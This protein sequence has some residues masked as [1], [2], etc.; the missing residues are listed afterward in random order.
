MCIWSFFWRAPHG[1]RCVFWRCF[2]RA[3]V[4]FLFTIPSFF[5][6]LTSFILACNS[7]LFWH[8]SSIFWRAPRGFLAWL[9]CLIWCVHHFFF[10][11]PPPPWFLVCFF[12][13]RWGFLFAIPSYFF[14]LSPHLFWRLIH[15]CFVVY[16]HGYFFDVPLIFFFIYIGVFSPSFQYLYN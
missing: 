8:I 1:F 14:R 16:V 12:S 11:V 13:V 4:G 15:V 6:A 5:L 10:G 7:R 2:C 3:L 9:S